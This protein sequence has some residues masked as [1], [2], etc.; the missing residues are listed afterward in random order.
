MV[1]RC[2]LR[3]QRGGDRLPCARWGAVASIAGFDERI[4]SLVANH[5]C[6][7]FEAAERGVLAALVDEFPAEESPTR[8]A[9]WYADMTTGPAGEDLDVA[10]RLAEIRTRYGSD[11]LVTRFWERAEPAILAAVQRTESR[12]TSVGQPM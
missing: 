12:L 4:A 2:R 10:D 1:A 8:D 5:S 9:L 3:P 6:A 7:V 11:H